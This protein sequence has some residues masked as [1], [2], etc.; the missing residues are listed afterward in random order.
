[1]YGSGQPLYVR[2]LVC[3][4][5]QRNRKR[6][7]KRKRKATKAACLAAALEHALLHILHMS[8]EVTLLLS[9]P[10]VWELQMQQRRWPNQEMHARRAH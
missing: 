10:S 6:N 1:M 9:S 3:T 5:Q 7:R 2:R 8:F 4:C